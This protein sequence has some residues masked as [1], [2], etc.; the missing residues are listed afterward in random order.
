MR[1]QNMSSFL[2]FSPRPKTC[3]PFE[4]KLIILRT[5]M[6]ETPRLIASLESL[7][8]SNSIFSVSTRQFLGVASRKSR[9]ITYY[10]Y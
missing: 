9:Y 4:S 7:G 2:F 8:T 3:D 6:L 5:Q 10:M 1:S